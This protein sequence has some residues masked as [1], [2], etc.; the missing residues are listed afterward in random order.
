MGKYDWGWCSDGI[1]KSVL[2]GYPQLVIVN[3][4]FDEPGICATLDIK[5]FEFRPRNSLPKRFH[6]F[7]L[8]PK[9]YKNAC[10][11][12]SSTTLSMSF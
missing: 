6:K 12:P 9:M 3:I 2:A 10:L 11:L 4:C 5:F 8:F 1:R 7:I